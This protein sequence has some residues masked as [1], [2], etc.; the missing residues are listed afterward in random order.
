MTEDERRILSHQLDRLEK[1]LIRCEKVDKAERNK[2]RA[3]RQQKKRE[4]DE[5]RRG[6][7]PPNDGPK[8]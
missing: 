7:A 6:P 2:Q 5:K 3:L 1:I 8:H 4:E